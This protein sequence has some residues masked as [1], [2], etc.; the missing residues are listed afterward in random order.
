MGD[1]CRTVL[2]VDG[3][4]GISSTGIRLIGL[5]YHSTANEKL[6]STFKKF[7]TEFGALP[8]F[9]NISMQIVVHLRK[10]CR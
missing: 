9:K 10:T 1:Y 4:K 7:S 8:L 2:C 3:D 5:D 6:L